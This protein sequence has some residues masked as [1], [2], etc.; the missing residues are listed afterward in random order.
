[1]ANLTAAG[2]TT[3]VLDVADLNS[4]NQAKD[5]VMKL[6]GG[7]LDILVNNACVSFFHPENYWKTI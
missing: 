2:I 4:V 1:M 3:L 6:T 5:E 7:M